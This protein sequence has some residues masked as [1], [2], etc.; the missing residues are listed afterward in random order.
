MMK[1]KKKSPITMTGA[2]VFTTMV[3]LYGLDDRFERSC[4][5]HP[6]SSVAW[7]QV[8]GDYKHPCSVSH[9]DFEFLLYFSS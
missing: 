6:S 7:L 2:C 3:F 8:R 5:S 4:D 1:K 9:S